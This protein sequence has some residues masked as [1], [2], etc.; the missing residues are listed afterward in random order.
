MDFN[1]LR[2]ILSIILQ[3]KKLIGRVSYKDDSKSKDANNAD[4]TGKVVLNIEE[5][6]VVV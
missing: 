5:N 1:K 6:K 4:K 2:T 3:Q